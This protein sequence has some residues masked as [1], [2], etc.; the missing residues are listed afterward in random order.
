M[1]F[2]W[3][4]LLLLFPV[5]ALS[6]ELYSYYMLNQELEILSATKE[7]VSYVKVPRFVRVVTREELDRWGVKNLFDLFEK[8]PEF[9][10]YRSYF[11]LNAVGALGIR[12][13]YYSEKVQVLIDGMPIFDP[14]NGSSFSVNN[15]FSLS[16]VKQVEIVYGPMTSL[17]GFNA[18]LVVINLV[19]YSPKD[20]KFKS[21]V[22]LNTGGDDEASIVRSFRRKGL[23]GIISL[24]YDEK[25]TPHRTYIDYK[26]QSGNYSRYRKNFSYYLKLDYDSG[27]YLKS[28]GVDRDDHFPVTISFLTSTGNSFARRRAF[29]NRIGLKKSFEDWNV[30]LYTYL[31]HFI[32]KRGYNICPFNHSFCKLL[33]R[34][35]PVAVEK[36]YVNN[37][38]LGILISRKTDYGKLLFGSE[39]YEADMYK[40]KLSANFDPYSISPVSPN[41]TFSYQDLPDD[42]KLLPEHLRTVF[43]SYFQY[44][45]NLSDTYSLLFNLRWD[46][47]NDVGKAWS[48]SVALM[49]KYGMWSFKLNAGRAIRIPDFESLYTKNNPFLRGNPHLKLEKEDS[50][51]PSIEYAGEKTRFSFMVYKSWFRNFIY[52]KQISPVSYEWDNAGCSVRT[53]GFVASLTRKVTSSVGVSFNFFRK[54]SSSCNHSEYLRVP[55]EKFTGD[56]FYDS[57]KFSANLSLV[58]YSRVLANIP[59]PGYGRLDL[60]VAY[61]VSKKSKISISVRNLLDKDY[62]Y[63]NGVPGDERTLWLGWQYSY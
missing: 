10:P 51:M 15:N 46:R 20:L 13:S 8:L 23:R 59:V 44:F 19:T 56:I 27:L 16:N 60:N 5:V 33:F 34:E 26:G 61:R 57:G 2:L 29:V 24:T 38:G 47:T 17:Y 54:F 49:K 58:A 12:Q 25:E 11:G 37:P 48:Y 63:P 52:K 9:Y 30:D 4:I 22:T 36:R 62:Y 45:W 18:S 7:K 28:Y 39:Y 35:E 32:L 53:S 43:S 55:K 42:K 14:S 21:S 3:V 1:V 6:Q 50:I 41:V 31:N 40:T